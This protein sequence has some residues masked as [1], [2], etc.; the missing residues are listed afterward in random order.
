MLEKGTFATNVFSRPVA[1]EGAQG[2]RAPLFYP[3]KWDK[4]RQRRKLKNL[5]METRNERKK[6]KEEN[7]ALDL[8][9]FTNIIIYV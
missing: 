6:K 9:F 8:I 7:M 2:A 5:K 1:R 4:L 3:R